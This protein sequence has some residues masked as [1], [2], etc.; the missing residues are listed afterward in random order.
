[1]KKDESARDGQKVRTEGAPDRSSHNLKGGIMGT[2]AFKGGPS[3]VSH[4]LSG[5]GKANVDYQKK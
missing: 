3:D 4:S 5:A 2:K 1:M